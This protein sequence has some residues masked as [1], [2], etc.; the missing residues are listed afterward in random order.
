MAL[1]LLPGSNKLKTTVCLLFLIIGIVSVRSARILDEVATDPSVLAADVPT[2]AGTAAQ[3]PA[4]APAAADNANSILPPVIEA[5]P[6]VVDNPEPPVVDT[7]EAPAAPG[8]MATAPVAGPLLTLP[9]AGATTAPVVAPGVVASD[10]KQPQL[11]FFMHDVIG[12]SHPSARVVTGLIANSEISGVPFSK[13]NNN[14]FPVSGGLPLVNGNN[15][16]NLNSINNVNGLINNNNLPFLTGINGAQV[17]TI[18]QN[19]GT[20]NVVS[21]G[22][23]QP[24][25]TAG[26]LPSGAT[27]EKLMFGSITVFDDE[28]TE[29]HELG[30]AVVGR[31]QGFYLASSLDGTSQ[32]IAITAI[33]HGGDH[34]VDDSISFFGVHRTASPDSQ[35]A[36][37]GGTGKY[38]H[39][40]GYA[41]V[42][43]LPIEDQHT[44]DGVDTIAEFTV[45]FSD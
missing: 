23:N 1:D 12:G 5:A 13:P 10:A 42:V 36:I 33:L 20:N 31:A 28:L 27:L 17:N 8:I 21:G 9:V 6:P 45:Y 7:P 4:V 22:N 35:I 18:I 11:S 34:G 24:F 25:V 30:S 40:K 3:L 37:V 44:T 26:V 2:D 41:S 14:I 43:T 16:N 29:G 39:A 32:T 15:I 19:T 38:E